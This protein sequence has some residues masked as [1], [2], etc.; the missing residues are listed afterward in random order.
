MLAGG[1][2]SPFAGGAFPAV[3]SNEANEQ[4]AAGRVPDV[5]DD[6]VATPAVAVGEVM[7]AHDLGITREA[8]R[9]VGGLRRHL[10]HAAAMSATLAA[11]GIAFRIVVGATF[12]LMACG[13]LRGIALVKHDCFGEI[14]GQPMIDLV[15]PRHLFSGERHALA[16]RVW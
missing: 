4:A 1:G 9:Q 15:P 16:H 10:A 6:P 14:R 7:A 2:I 3:R 8:A 5:A 13:V 12:K 11:W